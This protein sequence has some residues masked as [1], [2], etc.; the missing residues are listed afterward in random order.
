MK[1]DSEVTD[2]VRSILREETPRD[3]QKTVG[4]SQISNPCTKCLAEAIA[5]ANPDSGAKS[6]QSEYDMGA[7]IGTAIHEWLELNNHDMYALKEY[8]GLVDVVEG[9]G[10][11]RSTTDLYRVDKH[12]LVDYKTTTRAKLEVYLRDWK[13]GVNNKTIDMYFRQATLYA[14]MVEDKVDKVSL[15]FICRDG[16]KIDRDVVAISIPYDEHI[17]VGA[18]NRV[19]KIHAWLVENNWAYDWLNS[20]DD[21]FVC[22][23]VRPRELPELDDL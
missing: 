22:N 12:N 2:Y 13:E 7:K 14:Y 9:Y 15:C 19:R 16:Q 17:A 1:I 3:R 23:Y 10:D 4:A 8:N 11:I 20:D 18:L 5:M 6:R 21:C